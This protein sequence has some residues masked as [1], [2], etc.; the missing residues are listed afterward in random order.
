ML[1]SARNHTATVTGLS[2]LLPLFIT[3]P[4]FG[5][6]WGIGAGRERRTHD[7]ER[8]KVRGGQVTNNDG[9]EKEP[10]GGPNHRM[11]RTATIGSVGKENR[12]NM[13]HVDGK[14]ESAGREGGS[15]SVSATDGRT[16]TDRTREMV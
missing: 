6:R 7:S 10:L 3:F 13:T 15:P 9:R 4:V 8:D 11:S 2:L 12:R 5:F 16:Y 14:T 1:K